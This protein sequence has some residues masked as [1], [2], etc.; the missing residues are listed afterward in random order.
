M[1]IDTR[2]LDLA[3]LNTCTADEFADLLDGTLENARFLVRRAAASRPFADRDALHR[4]LLEQI[5]DLAE[6]DLVAFLSG[7]PELAGLEARAGTMTTHSTAEQGWLN[8]GGLSD[9]EATRWNQLNARYRTRFGFP[10]IIR[11]AEHDYDSLLANFEQRLGNDR[12]S[13]LRIAVTEIAKI[14]GNRLATWLTE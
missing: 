4:A 8:L 10:F 2:G 5:E 7:H 11:V 3:R 12:Q 13:E 6:A 9:S 1:T 14:S